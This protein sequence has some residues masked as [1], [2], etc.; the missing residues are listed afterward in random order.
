MREE[1]D[2]LEDVQR[3]GHRSQVS[4]PL[5]RDA[6]A[7]GVITIAAHE[8][9]GFSDS[10]IQ[11]LQTFAEQAVI[12]IISAETYRALQTRTSVLQ[13]TLEFQTATSEVLKVISRSTFDLQP[14]LDTVV[15]TAAQLCDADQA[16]IIRR[17]GEL[18]RLVANHG[19]PPEYETFLRGRGAFPIDRAPRNVGPRAIREGRVVHVHDA[20]AEP[21]YAEAAITLGKQRT[22]LGVPL[23]REGEVI[24]SILLARQRV[25]PF[26]DG[27][28]EL[29]STF[30][31]QAVIA[32]ENTRL[33]TEQREALEQQTATAEVLRVINS[34]PGDLSPVF[35]AI[36]NKA[37]ALCGATVGNLTVYKDGYFQALATHGLPEEIVSLL[38]QPFRPNPNTQGLIDGVRF[39]QIE[40]IRAIEISSQGPI[41]RALVSQT[42]VR[43]VLF[44]PLRKD[45]AF[46]GFISAHRPDVRLFSEK[47]IALLENFAAQ[48]VI[49]ME[50]ARLLD[51]LRERTAALAERNNAYGERIKQQAATID[52]LKAMSGSPG[53][54][55]PVFNQ[56]IR[57][58]VDLCDGTLS[59]LYE[60]DGAVVHLR[61]FYG[62][63]P[64]AAAAS[65][66]AALFPMT[67][68]RG[69]I[70]CRAILDRQAIHITDY[71][72]DPDLLP[73]VKALGHGSQLTIPLMREGAAIGAISLN[74]KQ[75]GF[76]D[77]QVELLMT[78]AEQA[79]IAISSAETYRAL[80]TRT[81]DLQES[82][83]YQTATSDVLKVISRST[84]DLQPVLDTVVETAA[85][86]CEAEMVSI[87]LLDGDLSRAVA[88]HGYPP[89][90]W[91]H[92]MS[93]EPIRLTPD[94]VTV[95]A[96]TMLEGRVVHIHDV[97]AVPG[98]PVE[99]ITLGKQRTTLGI[100]LL[101]DG[102]VIGN[103]GL[104]RQR[105]AP[106]TDRQ[107][108][109]VQ[110]FADQAVMAMENARLL[111]EV[112]QRQEE[113]RI[114]F[115]NMG[116]GVAMF[117]DT[118][119]LVAWNRKFQDSWMYPTMS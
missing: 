119:N 74:G 51:E 14:V 38:R 37:H 40:D 95:G 102:K 101:R 81:S 79:V 34:S 27:Q 97:A 106:F 84:F 69:S 115:E 118:Q 76:T 105:L 5:L 86:L 9:G 11:L 4:V 62:T 117:D 8:P 17:E 19:F 93:L 64:T 78:F 58:A 111:E 63:G 92:W 29:V 24:G 50:N 91:A 49:A 66:Y 36:L 99:H 55:Q 88:N 61:S 1:V 96:R 104:A 75:G 98:Y 59:A 6:R 33:I 89:E 108:A 65:D 22:S 15:E 110:N 77:S 71:Q 12:A 42:D 109:L 44:V 94:M 87:N 23:L 85:R 54:P 67:P 28:I 2:L 114:T 10:Q 83:E 53:D 82:L 16:V 3:L 72:A 103:I 116:D 52:V 45:G 107:I 56:I 48:A 46:F 43:T 21:G 7:I 80:Q 39:Y 26:T 100:P 47:E 70:M 31:D 112:R 68:T 60:Y 90:I 13:E 20:A 30:A 41:T 18:M 35:D 57:R 32:I 73:A 25:K 113:L